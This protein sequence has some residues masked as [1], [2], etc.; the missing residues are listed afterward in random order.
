MGLVVAA[1]V[2]VAAPGAGAEGK[3]RRHPAL[4]GVKCPP[5][6]PAVND[7]CPVWA[8]V[9]DNANGHAQYGVD[10]LT[11][12]AISPKGDRAFVTGTSWDDGSGS[13][14][15]VTAAYDL[16]DGKELWIK[17]W[18][19]SGTQLATGILVSADGSRVFV[20]GVDEFSFGG[21]GDVVTLAYQ[22]SNGQE[23]W[24]SIYD[25]PQHRQDISVG[26]VLSGD[27][28][29]LYVGGQSASGGVPDGAL[30]LALD[31]GSGDRLWALR[32][33]PKGLVENV[34]ALASG[35]GDRVYMAGYTRPQSSLLIRDYLV[36]AF[37]DDREQDRGVLDWS[38]AYDGNGGTA[39]D[40]ANA[41]AVSG[42]G[43][44][45]AVTGRS[46]RSSGGAA[47]YATVLLDATNGSQVWAAR[48]GGRADANY[49]SGNAIAFSPSGDH[50]FVTGQAG[51]MVD[52]RSGYGTVAYETAT[53]NQLWDDVRNGPA[54]YYSIAHAVLV[55]PDGSRVYVTG[56]DG[57]ANVRDVVTVAYDAN[58]TRIWTGRY[59]DGSGPDWDIGI[60][61]AISPDG[62]RL[63]VG[64]QAQHKVSTD[65]ANGSDYVTLAYDT[66]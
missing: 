12:V 40:L 25:D 66:A 20:T 53:G 1:A 29:R 6:I 4:P 60:V 30:L 61:A 44:R 26:A 10:S 47:D 22:A 33:D 35:P 5:V 14:D 64:T 58:G 59:N 23:I 55:S 46:E 37:H 45:V 52:R 9:Y 42:D 63:L 21:D 16:K 34:L 15:L 50:V 65:G 17:R 38:A 2:V 36:L 39:I 32:H 49:T 27:G 48:Y 19:G 7:R 8:S 24:S 57:R 11:R 51:N 31:S 56:E 3:A 54:D 62:K 28:S 41:L 13:N 18:P 43:S